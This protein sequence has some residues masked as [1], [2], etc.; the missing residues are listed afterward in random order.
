MVTYRVTSKDKRETDRIPTMNRRGG[1]SGSKR[2]T[3]VYTQ[4]TLLI[5]MLDGKSKE[6]VW[7]ATCKDS[8]NDAT[9]FQKRLGE[10]VEKAFRK[11]PPK[12]K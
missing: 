2:T 8:Q 3:R 11:F 9:K 10:D 4:G 1:Y 7:R 6:L 5:D 12:K